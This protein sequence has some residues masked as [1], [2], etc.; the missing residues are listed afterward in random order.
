MSLAVL[1]IEDSENDTQLLLEELKK[2]GYDPAHERVETASAMTSALE[3]RRWD[4]ILSDYTMPDF[5]GP[6]ALKLLR[7]KKLDLPFIVVSGT[8]GEEAAVEMMKAGANDY[9]TKAN[10]SRLVPAIEREI[11]TAQSRQARA[12]AEQAMRHLAA[13]VE[14]TEDAVY[15]MDLRGTL[16]SWNR[17][18]EKIFG[19]RTEEILGRSVALLFPFDQRDELITNME[20]IR[21]GENVG[22]YETL[23]IRKD[24]QFIPVSATI[25]P[26]RDESG[27]I[28]GASAITRDITHR[29]REERERTELIQELTDALKQVK[30]LNGLLPICASCKRIRDDRG[31]WQQVET[32]ISAHTNAILT[33]GICPEC[34]KQYKAVNK[35]E[36]KA[37]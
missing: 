37:A 10:L 15:G 19:Y 34:L 3:R 26:I 13:I 30:T 27:K 22:R 17:A 18:A 16:T 5:S 28:V 1:I 4:V 23:R 8:Y 9:I 25:S 21:N 33:H 12:K 14:S 11:E 20:K 2:K 6:E 36:K 29:K 24:G 35:M 31:Y 7:D 32:Y